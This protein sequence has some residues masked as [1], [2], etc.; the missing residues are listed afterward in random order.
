MSEVVAETPPPPSH[1][2]AIF[3]GRPF[4][5]MA[6]MT[7][8]AGYLDAVGYAHLSG[9]YVSFMSGNSA[10]LGL[11]IA[12]GDLRSIAQA[13]AVV[14]SFVVGAT[15]AAVLTEVWGQ[16]RV[17]RILWIEFILIAT[18]TLLIV[19]GVGFAS[20]L[21]VAVAMGMQ[22]ILHRTIAGADI[23]K[24]F[25]TGVLFDTSRQIAL[26]LLG[27]ARAASIAYAAAGW[28]AFVAGVAAGGTML[29][30]V[31]LGPTLL[32]ACAVLAVAAVAHGVAASGARG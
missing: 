25:I 26:V 13:L 10:R 30:V 17:G 7:A 24:T 3:T 14:A 16:V 31:S 5:F 12:A 11:D 27:R 18:G 29:H 20:F 32:L 9:L 8:L 21:P 1:D 2:A 15:G 22:N 28:V 6:A 23:G 19:G 4:A